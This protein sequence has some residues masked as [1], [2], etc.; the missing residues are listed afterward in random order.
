M[1]DDDET[2]LSPE[3]H[4]QQFLVLCEQYMLGQISAEEFEALRPHHQPDY[5]AIL[6]A[7]YRVEH[8]SILARLGRIFRRAR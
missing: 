3:R 2:P 7:L 5:R 6:A 4:H 1:N 8:P